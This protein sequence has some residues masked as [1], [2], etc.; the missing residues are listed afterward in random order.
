MTRK[1]KTVSSLIGNKGESWGKKPG[2]DGSTCAKCIIARP[3]SVP[4]ES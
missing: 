2:L 3:W 4:H 1:L